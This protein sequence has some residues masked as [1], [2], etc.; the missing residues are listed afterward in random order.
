MTKI[1]GGFEQKRSG[2]NSL[3]LYFP[4]GH[5][6]SLQFRVPN[7]SYQAT[8]EALPNRAPFQDSRVRFTRP[9]HLSTSHPFQKEEVR[10][11]SKPIPRTVSLSLI[12]FN[13][14][15]HPVQEPLKMKRSPY[16]GEKESS[17]L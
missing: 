14:G 1:E 7:Q 3:H 17:S 11:D 10:G 13:S 15:N 2:N 9:Q 12:F 5:Q 16:S 6:T 4:R 8:T